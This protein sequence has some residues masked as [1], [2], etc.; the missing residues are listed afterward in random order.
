MNRDLVVA[1]KAFPYILERVLKQLEQGKYPDAVAQ[2]PPE[3]TAS[4]DRRN[5]VA[6]IVASA[7]HQKLV[8]NAFS[9]TAD[10]AHIALK[11]AASRNF[12]AA[13]QALIEAGI[14][15]TASDNAAL[16]A[17]A[18][19][20]NSAIMALLIGHGATIP[21]N[22]AKLIVRLVENGQT[23]TGSGGS[24]ACIARLLT[25]TDTPFLAGI[26]SECIRM[27]RREVLHIILSNP[28]LIATHGE[29]A[30]QLAAVYGR[31]AIFQWLASK[32][33]GSLTKA[34]TVFAYA[35]RFEMAERVF[36]LYRKRVDIH[37]KDNLLFKWCVSDAPIIRLPSRGRKLVELVIRCAA[38]ESLNIIDSAKTYKHGDKMA[39]CVFLLR[40]ATKLVILPKDIWR[41][42]S[43]SNRAL[44]IN[45]LTSTHHHEWCGKVSRVQAQHIKALRR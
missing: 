7:I 17:A 18:I 3:I 1:V 34:F 14:D 13:T 24:I 16:C 43:P 41:N 36:S 38:D 40:M 2:C 22:P 19:K 37:N 28:N 39:F 29:F 25:I 6:L 32:M 23:R 44:W 4:E 45:G 21:Q 35:G 42:T 8:K 27:D 11:I 26:L 20:G 9:K 31:F 5:W 15:V 12:W 33:R 10:G 30:T